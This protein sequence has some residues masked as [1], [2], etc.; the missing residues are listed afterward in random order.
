MG[1]YSLDFAEGW[2]AYF[3]KLDKSMRER[4]WRKIQQ[5]KTIPHSRHLKHGLDYFVSEVGQYRIAYKINEEKK[6]KIL[7][8]V[9]DHKDYEKW[10]GL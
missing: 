7:Y 6:T 9:G 1:E 3:E 8:F 2:E 5:L 4:V 10:L